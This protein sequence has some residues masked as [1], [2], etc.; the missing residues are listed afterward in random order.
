VKPD[1][2]AAQN[3]DDLALT[4]FSVALTF[5]PGDLSVTAVAKDGAGKGRATLCSE[6]EVLRLELSPS[7]LEGVVLD[8]KKKKRKVCFHFLCPAPE[9]GVGYTLITLSVCLSCLHPG[10]FFL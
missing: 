9:G 8:L 4:Y 7:I 10:S 2:D 5:K 6:E 3:A 1:P